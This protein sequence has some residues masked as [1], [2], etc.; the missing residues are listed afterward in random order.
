MTLSRQWGTVPWANTLGDGGTYPRG[1]A[2][3]GDWDQAVLNKRN[4]RRGKRV[5]RWVLVESWDSQ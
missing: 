4:F 5:S 3:D 1:D 2:E